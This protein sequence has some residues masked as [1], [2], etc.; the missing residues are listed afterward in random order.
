MS[1]LRTRSPNDRAIR[2]AAAAAV[3]LAGLLAFSAPVHT[4]EAA[5]WAITNARIV[6]VSSP[7]LEKGTIIIRNGI[8]EAVGASIT[9]PGDA[10]VFDGAGLTIYPGLI[11][12]LS[13]VGIEEARPQA[14]AG[15]RPAATPAMPARPGAPAQQQ[16]EGE[17]SEESRGLTPYKQAADMISSTH[18]KIESARNAGITTALAA[19]RA[20]FFP[21][22]SSVINLSGRAVGHM[23]VKTPVAYHINMSQARGFGGG[24]PGSQM[25]VIAH[26]KQTLMDAQRYE[27]VWNQY[28]TTPGVPR[29]EYSPALEA[30]QPA[31]KRQLPVVIGGNT[32]PEVE[33]ALAVAEEFNLNPVIAGGMEAAPVAALLKQKN[34]P[35]LL[36]VKF[37][38][39]ERDADPEAREELE[40]LKRRIEA[41]ANAAAL[42][43]A[44]VRFAFISDD[45]ANP[46]D[47]IRNVGKAVEAGL[48]R[49]AALKALTLIPAEILGIADRFGSIETNK[50]ANLVLATGDIFAANTRV[51]YVFVDG[52]RFE[53]PEPETPA[54]RPSAGPGG[55]APPRALDVS[56][57]WNLVLNSPQGAMDISLVVK[58]SGSSITGAVSSML[59]TTEIYDGTVTGN[60]M[61]FKVSV[62]PPGMGGSIEVVFSGTIEGTQISGSASVGEMGS[63]DFTGAKTPGEL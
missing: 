59:G 28:R 52:Q 46:R 40:S 6:P 12:A 29:P 19:P 16:P 14:Q 44:G 48:D 41:P 51:K 49:Q 26:I 13:D 43:K 33:R 42:A 32:P 38:E 47:F 58:Q 37:V 53:I 1:V 45:M 50:T 61:S 27:A 36:A 21:G 25:G 35:V 30:L 8:I 22:Q 62:A 10:R 7:T 56:G 20:G 60:R 55:A 57:T 4:Q 54:E 31:L 39:R 17:P 5:V 18:R 15:Q 23:V 2:R 34:V 3:L 11:D 24:Y 9:I 63:M